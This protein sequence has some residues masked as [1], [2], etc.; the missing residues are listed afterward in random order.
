MLEARRRPRAP[1]SGRWRRSA[2]LSPLVAALVLP[3]TAGVAS[4]THPALPSRPLATQ[5]SNPL[6][7]DVPGDG[8]VDSCAD[9]TVLRGQQPGDRNWYMYCTTDPLNDTNRDAAGKLVFNKVPQMVSRDLV[10][11]TYVGN[12]FTANPSWAAEGASLWAPE[13]VYSSTF[14]RYYMFVTVTETTA[15]GGGSDTC[16]GDG[17]IGVATSDDPTGPWTFS[18]QPVVRPRIDPESPT[19]ATTGCRGYFWNFDP[20]VLGDT[21]GTASTLYYGSYYGGVFGSPVTFTATGATTGDVAKHT[22]VT[23]GNRYEGANVVKRGAYYYLFAS[24]TDC[25]NGALTGYSVFAG[26]STSPLGPFV[27]REGNSLLAGRVGGTPVISM[28]GNR[29]TGTGHNTVFRDLAG[30]WWTIYHAVDRTDPFFT[31]DV[32]PG[33]R[34]FTKR[35]ALLD[36]IEWVGGW[37][38]VRGG[39]WASDMPMPSP[40]AQPRQSDRYLGERVQP[41]VLGAQL[42]A[43]SDEFNGAR[44]GSRW[45]WVRPPAEGT[46]R[47]ANGSFRFDTQAGDLFVDSNTA[48]VLTRPAPVGDYAVETR[49]RLNVPDDGKAYN[50][51]QAGL[52]VYKDDDNFIKLVNASIWETRQTE[53]AKELKPV[54]IPGQSRYGNTVVGPPADWT[55]LRIVVDRLSADERAQAGGDTERY[56]AYTSQDGQRYVRG[57]TW[58]HSLG[59]ARI[60][61]VSMGGTGFTADFDFVRTYELRAGSRG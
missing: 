57:G 2:L 44:L 38:M 45:T 29:W 13:V 55:Y 25:C 32:A 10:N 42:R 3:L 50:F 18:D 6:K 60:G 8:T 30:Q 24:A 1:G 58:T 51:R 35:P 53:F 7:P 48:S 23:I 15:A 11:W 41:Q 52:V 43:A 33:A 31:T 26:R 34:G 59:R 47:V 4:A 54:T 21:V 49:V 36:P 28:N 19:N 56:T 22:R 5:Y 39:L 46:Y 37:P 17:A 16:G 61:L 9:P 20:D 14:D 12:A 27:D 40:A